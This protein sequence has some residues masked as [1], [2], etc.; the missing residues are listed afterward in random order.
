VSAYERLRWA[1]ALATTLQ[2]WSSNQIAAFFM[3]PL[4]GIVA[5]LYIRTFDNKNAHLFDVET[6]K[7]ALFCTFVA[8][9]MAWVTSFVINYIWTSPGTLHRE[10]HSE[11]QQRNETIR[12]LETKLAETP[13]LPPHELAKQTMVKNLIENATPQ[14]LQVLKVLANYDEIYYEQVYNQHPRAVIDS[15]VAKWQHK[16]IAVRL[17][18]GTNRTFWSIPPGIKDALTQVLYERDQAD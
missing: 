5:A 3:S 11:I 18:A 10:Q 2:F 17:E 8:Y 1:K 7:L 14:E 13:K 12:G 16:L 6:A 4:V 9:V 15:S